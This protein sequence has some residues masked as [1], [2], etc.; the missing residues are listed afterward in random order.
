[1][2]QSDELGRL[3][4]EGRIVGY[5]ATH[6]EMTGLFNR[7]AFEDRRAALKETDGTCGVI[8]G[9]LNGLKYANDHFGHAAGDALLVRFS[10]M[11][12]GIFRQNEVFH[13]RFPD[14]KR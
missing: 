4:N 9:D 12:T 13:E 11:L 7:R 3:E 6:D 1:M 5:H 2:I 14:A 8:F 10:E